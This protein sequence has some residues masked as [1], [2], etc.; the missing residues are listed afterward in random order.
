MTTN[1]DVEIQKINMEMPHFEP[2]NPNI[3]LGEC[4][5]VEKYHKVLA[6]VDEYEFENKIT[7]EQA[8]WLRLTATRFLT[9]NFENIANY[10]CYTDKNMQTLMKE[11]LLVI[12]DLHDAIRN[13]FIN[14][15]KKLKE[16][17]IRQEQD[18][19]YTHE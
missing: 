14:I 17:L 16:A 6:Q 11:Q 13:S 2:T 12:I 10:F 9:F 18:E 15:D 19:K 4:V 1:T 8:D 5:D 7:K 3:T